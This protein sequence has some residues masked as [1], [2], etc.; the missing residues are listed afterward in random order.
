MSVAQRLMKME[1]RGTPIGIAGSL[2]GMLFTCTITHGNN[3]WN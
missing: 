1:L 2:A 3:P